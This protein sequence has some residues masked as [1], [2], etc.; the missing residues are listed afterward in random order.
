MRSKRSDFT[1]T[2]QPMPI[3]STFATVAPGGL[4]R[5]AIWWIKLGIRPER[6][7]PAKPQE[8]GRHERIHLTLKKEATKPAAQNLLQ[9]QARFDDFLEDDR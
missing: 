2:P 1:V 6:I 4:S 5:L 3:T 8:N 7:A 9:Q